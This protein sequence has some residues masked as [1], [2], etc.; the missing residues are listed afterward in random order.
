MKNKEILIKLLT[1][2]QEE[3]IH[4]KF[5]FNCF[6]MGSSKNPK[7]PN[8]GTV[9]CLAGELPRFDSNW[10]FC[11][12]GAFLNKKNISLDKYFDLSSD[13]GDALFIPMQQS[14]LGLENISY[15]ATLEQVQANGWKV[16][17]LIE[18]NEL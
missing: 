16:L 11:E 5:D 12:S 14:R 15:D 2:K 18:E 6:N 8:C 7:I 10:Y 3:S 17:K 13:Y 4:E 1:F 9:G